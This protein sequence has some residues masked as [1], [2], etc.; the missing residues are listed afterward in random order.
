MSDN[1]QR[2]GN[3]LTCGRRWTSDDVASLEKLASTTSPKLIAKKLKRSYESV[4]QKAKQRKVSFLA[5]RRR[6]MEE[7]TKPNL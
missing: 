6:N 4:R 2:R 5:E 1:Y 7:K 3:Q